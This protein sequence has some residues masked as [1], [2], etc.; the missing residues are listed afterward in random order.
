MYFAIIVDLEKRFIKSLHYVVEY[1]VVHIV[2]D[3]IVDL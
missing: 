3:H 2:N 1:F